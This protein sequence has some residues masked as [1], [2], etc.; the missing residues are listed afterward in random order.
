MNLYRDGKLFGRLT[1]YGYETPWATA[2]LTPAEPDDYKTLCQVSYLLNVV[3]DE[4]DVAET[5]RDEDQRYEQAL[6]QLRISEADVQQFHASQ[7]EIHEAECPALQ[8]S[9]TLYECDSDGWI[10]W[11][12]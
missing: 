2:T 9:I 5:D 11:R 1:H 8:G 12:W 3:L 7:W 4:M 10:R 6:V